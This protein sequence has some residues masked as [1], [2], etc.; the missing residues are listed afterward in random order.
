MSVSQIALSTDAGITRNVKT[1]STSLEKN[2]KGSNNVLVQ[3]PINA[4]KIIRTKNNMK[5]VA[6]VSNFG[7]FRSMSKTT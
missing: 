5:C 1:G 3:D 2:D 7:M 6:G 4:S